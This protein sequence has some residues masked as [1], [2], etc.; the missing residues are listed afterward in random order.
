MA[1]YAEKDEVENRKTRE[2]FIYVLF[3]G[4]MLAGGYFS[5]KEHNI[6]LLNMKEYAVI[7]YAVAVI[8]IYYCI[9]KDVFIDADASLVILKS[10][11]LLQG[12]FLITSEDYIINRMN[13]G[14][15]KISGF[16]AIQLYGKDARD[17]FKNIGTGEVT[18]LCAD[19]STRSVVFTETKINDERKKKGF[20]VLSFRDIEEIRKMEN[21]LLSL[22]EI[23]EERVERRQVVLYSIQKK[24]G[25]GDRGKKKAG[26]GA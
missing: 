13:E 1:E 15:E 18:L 24:D 6:G 23:L 2:I 26:G 10:M 7:I 25:G 16:S 11:E 19:G 22:K 3:I 14:A 5:I 9:I 17:F 12:G 4:L 20:R 8:L 21:T